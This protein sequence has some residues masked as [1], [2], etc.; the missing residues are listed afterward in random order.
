MEA[1]GFITGALKGLKIDYVLS[2]PCDRVK[3]LLAKLDDVYGRRHIHLSRE[4][5][6][7]GIASGLFAG[8]KRYALFIQSSGVG[9]IFGALM[10]LIK[11]YKVPLPIFVSH[12]G[13]HRE[14]ILP[15]I[16]MGEV[17]ENLFKACGVPV[18]RVYDKSA[19]PIIP[20]AVE[21]A[22]RKREPIA[23][24]LSP[25]LF[26][27]EEYTNPVFEKERK[28][29]VSVKIEKSIQNPDMRRFEALAELLSFL[30]EKGDDETVLF[31][32]IGFPAREVYHLKNLLNVK[33]PVFYMLG[34][35][36]LVSSIALGYSI[37]TEKPVVSIDGD[38]SLLMN[39]GTLATCSA[40]APENFGIFC[41][42]NGTWGS[43]GDQE[44]FN[45]SRVDVEV[46]ARGMGFENTSSVWQRKDLRERLEWMA[47]VEKPFLQVVVNPGN[48]RVETI[49]MSPEDILGEVKVGARP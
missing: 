36:G 45:F 9:N 5:E 12:R 21:E 3:T 25:V 49:P 13:I 15:Q 11:T 37:A 14:K 7:L 38:G 26:E 33:N 6:G 23:I 39:T 28:K 47:E 46:V 20:K 19:L 42:D 16:L 30:K 31:A 43:T 32:N 8:G 27:G 17:T 44:N 41:V 29:R 1:T 48:E 40:Y 34:S 4:E 35:L 10:T 24:L 22:F 2:L 18:V